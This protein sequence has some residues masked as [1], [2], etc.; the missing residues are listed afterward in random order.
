MSNND[1]PFECIADQFGLRRLYPRGRLFS[2]AG[3]CDSGRMACEDQPSLS[4]TEDS[5]KP[6]IGACE[7]AV[8]IIFAGSENRTCLTGC[9]CPATVFKDPKVYPGCDIRKEKLAE[10]T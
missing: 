10:Q 6:E 1:G 5:A 7:F 8:G 9:F 3:D 4:E 2:G